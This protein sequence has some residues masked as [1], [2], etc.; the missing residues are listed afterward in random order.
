[1]IS[2]ISCIAKNGVIGKDGKLPWHIKEDLRWFNKNTIG[3]T[4]IMGN[5]TRKSIGL[6]LPGREN[7]VISSNKELG[8]HSFDDAIEV[9]G[10]VAYEVFVIGGASIYKQFLPYA[11][12][13]YLT[14]LN[15]EYEGDTYFPEWNREEFKLTESTPFEFGFFNIYERK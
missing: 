15:D 6:P 1:M 12:K 13:L 5:A 11:N 3:K 4:V 2:I 8:L 9:Y 10:N 7:F 14:E